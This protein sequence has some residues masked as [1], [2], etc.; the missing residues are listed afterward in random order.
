MTTILNYSLHKQKG[1]GWLD[2]KQIT[3]KN[4]WTIFLAARAFFTEKN[5]N[6]FTEEIT[7]FL[8]V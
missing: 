3:S 1:S 4:I 8:T 6:I 2:F 7:A 5:F